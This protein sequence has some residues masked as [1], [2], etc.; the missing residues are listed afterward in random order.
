MGDTKTIYEVSTWC[1]EIINSLKVL[2]KDILNIE[3]VNK[4]YDHFQKVVNGR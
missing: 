4:T 1:T 3:L 2:S